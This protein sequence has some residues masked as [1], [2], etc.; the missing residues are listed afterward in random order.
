MQELAARVM[1][2]ARN[3]SLFRGYLNWIGA[4][5]K[6]KKPKQKEP[7]KRE[8]QAIGRNGTGT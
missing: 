1:D 2:E 6:K 5:R 8:T 7:E 4:Q 3:Q